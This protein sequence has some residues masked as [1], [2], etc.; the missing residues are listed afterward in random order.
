MRY[1]LLS[2]LCSLLLIGV[3]GELDAQSRGDHWFLDDE[4]HFIFGDAGL[5]VDSDS[6]IISGEAKS[7]IS[8]PDGNCLF[9][10]TA[11]ELWSCD[12][13]LI[14]D[15]LQGDRSSSQGALIIPS[16]GDPDL[17][18]VITSDACLNTVNN[19]TIDGVAAS[20]VRAPVGGDVTIV[21]LNNALIPD[22]VAERL[23]ATPHANG[24]DYWLTVRQ[25]GT[26]TFLTW[27][28][29]PSGFSPIIRQ[30]IGTPDV[31]PLLGPD[32]DQ[33][34]TGKHRFS[35]DGRYLAYSSSH[36]LVELFDFDNGTG[37]FSNP[38]LL[39]DPAD[40]TGA[41]TYDVAFS[42]GS[43]FLYGGGQG[44][45]YGFY[46]YD[47]RGATDRESILASRTLL[48]VPNATSP[49]ESRSPLTMQI[50]PDGRLYFTLPSLVLPSGERV[51]PLGVINYPDSKGLACGF[52]AD[53][54][55]FGTGES[56][57]WLPNFIDTWFAD[58]SA[59]N[60]HP[61][62][63]FTVDTV[64]CPGEPLTLTLPWKDRPDLSVTWDVEGGTE[65]AA[66]DSSATFRFDAPG[67][68]RV[69]I[70]WQ[71][72]T[73][74]RDSAV[75]NVRVTA[76]FTVDAG[77]ERSICEGESTTLGMPSN[78]TLGKDV[79]IEWSAE[80]GERLQGPEPTVSPS[81]STT[82]RVVAR[83]TLAGCTSIDSVVVEVLPTIRVDLGEDL[84]LCGPGE[85]TLDAL[86]APESPDVR[87]QWQADDRLACD[88]CRSTTIDVTTGGHVI[89]TPIADGFCSTPDTLEITLVNPP[90]PLR[91]DTT[92][93]RGASVALS[94]SGQS[95][96]VGAIVSWSPTT[97]LDVP[98]SF[99]PTATPQETTTYAREVFH[100]SS[101]CTFRDS[102]T[103]NVV[104]L[105][106][107]DLVERLRLCPGDTLRVA[108]RT[109][110]SDVTLEW[111]GPSI[112]RTSGDSLVALAPP[113]G[114]GT[115]SLRATDT[116]NGCSAEASLVVE[117]RESRINLTMRRDYLI[118]SGLNQVVEIETSPIS[119]EDDI[120][121]IEGDITFDPRVMIMNPKP[122]AVMQEGALLE[123]WQ[124]ERSE[125][126][127]PGL[128]QVR[129]RAPAGD[130]LEGSGIL[131]RLIANLFLGPVNGS[132]IG[133]AFRM[134]GR[135]TSITEAP[136]FVR[137]DT[138]CEL[139]NRLLQISA[140]KY[141]PPVA[142]PN[143]TS[144]DAQITFALGL[145][146]LT[147][148]RAYDPSGQL[149]ATLVNETLAAGSHTV[150]WSNPPVG[151]YLIRLV[152]A[153]YT[154]EGSV[155]V[156]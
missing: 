76:P 57:A 18:W 48:S 102:V 129:L 148:L 110:G 94:T 121:L 3:T 127:A 34:A 125:V 45:R 73:G 67:E 143:P 61:L 96:P 26:A 105:P 70:I 25:P 43:C 13:T 74:M 80:S 115:Y 14:T 17:Y 59:C 50:A 155:M 7:S 153:G 98:A 64:L 90:D 11:T 93:C 75:G 4:L 131:M 79:V 88:T 154:G 21:Q 119:A 146:A 27:L 128:M 33:C 151:V 5:M 60:R 124:V 28:I 32:D 35:P 83:D 72:Q 92:I 46:Q 65:R 86:L 42:P 156:R 68:Y 36:D 101:G 55:R 126:T 152:S 53:Y 99:N 54:L 49:W 15:Q 134:N 107:I 132:E 23:D 52:Q 62:T 114:N 123:G 130:R 69:A 56:P 78:R 140:G 63:P 6:R 12:G 40:R 29:T 44:D 145:D 37:I 103:I 95:S 85:I 91:S 136:G 58:P 30:T 135:C 111:S 10:A 109:T 147:T 24:R 71:D 47:L 122:L 150:Q 87:L 106:T 120:D 1:F 112:L 19:F 20:L 118:W 138:L 51:Y 117:W 16:P 38:R 81:V 66:D 97:G 2:V 31:T 104:E 139:D 133:F 149:V 82:Y 108:A 84:L 22:I 141:Q 137:L 116:V 41:R 144:G 89:V 142:T 9:Y 113:S 39:V 8:S 100:E 77:E